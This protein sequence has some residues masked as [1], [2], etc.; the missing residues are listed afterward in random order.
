MA[1]SRSPLEQIQYGLQR[2]TS[3]EIAGPQQGYPLAYSPATRDQHSTSPES[4]KSLEHTDGFGV[5]EARVGEA[6]GGE[7]YGEQAYGGTR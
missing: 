2:P 5:H 7:D 6:Y 3:Y 4:F 1:Q